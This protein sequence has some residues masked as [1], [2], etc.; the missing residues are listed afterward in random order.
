[1]PDPARP[2]DGGRAL[3]LDLDGVIVLAEKPVPGAAAALG[4]LATRKIPFLIVTN[5][6]LVS[7][8][9]L[10][11]W[12]ASMGAPIP[13]DRFQSAREMSDAIDHAASKPV[14]TKALDEGV[15]QNARM[16][17]RQAP[18]DASAADRLEELARET[19]AWPRVAEAIREAAHASSNHETKLTL[20]FRVARIY[21]TDLKE[22]LRAEA[23]YQQIRELDPSS[24]VALRGIEGC[25]RSRGDHAD[26]SR[27]HRRQPE[28]AGAG[29]LWQR[30]PG[31]P[32]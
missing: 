32:A 24:Q 26:A 29:P 23:V 19:G 2:L 25:K 1:V 9:T 30:R 7:R 12:G 14:T 18:H 6:S 22:T 21:D 28:G 16:A 10:S 13:P 20:L 27:R 8:A 4:A 15:F 11:R 5:T 17:L 3:L 31:H